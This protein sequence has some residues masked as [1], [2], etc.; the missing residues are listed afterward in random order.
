MSNPYDQKF[1]PEEMALPQDWREQVAN[2]RLRNPPD[3]QRKLVSYLQEENSVLHERLRK[4]EIA[5]EKE[6][7]ACAKVAEE[8]GIAR[9]HYEAEG[10]GGKQDAKT[11]ANSIAALIRA[12]GER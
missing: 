7:E 6:R 10:R 2:L 4:L 8:Y 3:D 5:L 1:T 9:Y 11:A 12:R